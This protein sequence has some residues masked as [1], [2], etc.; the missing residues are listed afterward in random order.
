MSRKITTEG[1]R[2]LKADIARNNFRVD[3][4]GIKIGI[5]STS[6][7]AKDL[8]TSDIANG[9]LPGANNPEGKFQ[10]IQVLKDLKS[11]NVFADEEGRALAQIIHD[12]APG[13]ELLFHT[14]INDTGNIDDRSYSEAVNSLV[15]AGA[16]VIV[17]DALVP[18]TIFQDGEA[19]QAAKNAVDKGVTFISAAGNNGRTSYESDYRSDGTTFNFGGKAFE[20]LDF[21]PSTNVDFFQNITVT[22]DN[23]AIFPLLTWSDPNGQ[24]SSNLELFLVSSPTLPDENAENLLAV[25]D[26]PSATAID[27]PLRRLAYP[28]AKDQNLYLV[29]GRELNDTEAPRKIKWISTANGLD[30]TTKYEYININPFETGSSTIS[31]QANLAETIAVGAADPNQDFTSGKAMVRS[32]SSEGSSPILFND[33]GDPL[34]N[35]VSDPLFNDVGDPLFNPQKTTNSDPIARYEISNFDYAG[36]PLLNP[37]GRVK[38]DIIA[39]DGISTSVA[40]FETFPGTSAAAPGIAGI[41]ALMQQAAGG[42]DVLTPQQI[43][44]ILQNTSIPVNLGSGMSNPFPGVGLPQADLAVAQAQAISGNIGYDNGLH[45]LGVWL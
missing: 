4:S 40:G 30:R 35:G 9:E 3:G 45:G 25:S 8:L 21:D 14:A 44:E 12:Q 32:Y 6:F 43:K 37:Q 34:F 36:D 31:G 17:D 27:D 23:T 28:T 29:I 10:P 18:T 20:A 22:K 39:P 38:P 19:A 2:L 11:D 42:A 33:V 13:A 15:A 16:N 5:I 7:N 24:V 1:D 26:I 41:V